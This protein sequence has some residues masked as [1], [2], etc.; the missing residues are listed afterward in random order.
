M[1]HSWLVVLLALAAAASFAVSG[2]LK[3]VS[4][5]EVPDAQTMRPSALRRFAVAT[6]AHRLWMV[7]LLCDVA[8]VALQATA[9]HLGRISVVQPVLI[10]AVPITLIVR[11]RFSHHHIG[12]S[13]VAWAALLTLA[14]AGFVA[15]ASSS[16]DVAPHRVDRVPAYLAAGVGLLLGACCIELA[17]RRKS[18]RP[19]AALVGVA[20]GMVYASTA[21]LLKAISDIIAKDPVAVLW[22]WQTYVALVVGACGLMLGQLA[23]QAGPITASIGATSTV[24]PLASIVIGVV[25]FDESVGTGP[26]HGALL[27]GLLLLLTVAAIQL[28]RP[29]ADV[30]MENEPAGG[31]PTRTPG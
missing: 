8:G 25:V 31:V 15:I 27:A 26:G 20:V 23:F 5:G 11:S 21:A 6:L 28:A 30:L 7:A 3:H 4:A 29:T 18:P 13:E 2:S 12:R 1:N 9:L 24:D 17:R 16:P 10:T 19:A 14:L 22:S